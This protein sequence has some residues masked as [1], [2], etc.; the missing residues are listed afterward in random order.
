MESQ[1][2]FFVAPHQVEVRE[3]G[4]PAL[5]AG[6]VLVRTACSAISPGTEMLLYRGEFP[7]GLPLD[8][9]IDVLSSEF[10]YP[11]KY[12]YA[13][14]GEVISLGQGIDQSWLGRQVFA[15]QPH[16]S[17]FIS[18]ID[19][20]LLVPQDFSL[21]D[22]VFLPNMETAVNFI[23]DGAP[24]IGE[25][26]AVLGQGIVGLLTTALLTQFPLASLVTVD[27]FALR[28]HAS[29]ELGAS[30]SLDPGDPGFLEAARR[31]LQV[32]R[33]YAGADLVF[34][35]SGSPAA[36]DQAIALCGFNGRVLIGSWYGSKRSELSLGGHFHRSRI[37][38]ISSQVSTL[39][40]HLSARW[41]RARRFDLAWEMLRVF[42]PSHW[43]TQRFPIT[44]ARQ[45]YQLI[46]KNAEETIQVV[47]TY[48]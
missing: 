36:L 42:K 34:E 15:F 48:P 46:D 35:L 7:E 39:M 22:A 4:L 11:L 38:L 21:D 13:T 12:G 18:A 29:A 44:Q 6:Q 23:L 2:L 30:T 32:D 9:K 31:S 3:E 25:Q 43:I 1:S 10:A 26:V 33:Q 17:R 20:L 14:V 24:L 47:F 40:P 16:A 28:R 45:A 41:D 27:R 37:Q 5:Q 8:E 19:Q